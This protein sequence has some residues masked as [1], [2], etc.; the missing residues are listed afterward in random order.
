MKVQKKCSVINGA[1]IVSM[2]IGV[3]P[4]YSD[5]ANIIIDKQ[6]RGDSIKMDPRP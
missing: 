2:L 3:N 4:K 5:N 6:N 1:K